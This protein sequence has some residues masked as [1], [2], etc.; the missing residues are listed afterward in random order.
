VAA[1]PL[2]HLTTPLVR[3]T[4]VAAFEGWND[5]AEAASAAVRHLLAVSGATQVGALDP[6]D[7]YDFQVNR[8]TVSLASGRRSIEWPGTS[9]HAGRFPGQDGSGGRDLLLVDGLE[10]SIRWRSF[11]AELVAVATQVQAETVVLLGALL[12]DTPHRAATPVTGLSADA[13]L[14]LRLGLEPSRYEGP[15]GIVGVVHDAL[16]QAGVPTVS[17]WAAVPYY[18]AHPPCPKATLA[19]LHRVEDVL[20]EPLPTGDLPEDARAWVRAVEE[21]VEDDEELAGV[22]RQLEEEHEQTLQEASGDAIAAEFERYL[23][24]RRGHER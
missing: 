21:L 15:T 7:Y 6:E 8:P 4:I 12:A 9:L 19:L 22:V 18:V 10:P 17:F 3:P 24:R 11:A 23:R 5:A 14:G 1:V 20:D 16:E 13:G 2:L